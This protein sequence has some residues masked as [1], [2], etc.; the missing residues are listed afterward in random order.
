LLLLYV[1]SVAAEAVFVKVIFEL[2][3]SAPSRSATGGNQ[4]RMRLLFELKTS[5]RARVVL[6]PFQSAQPAAISSSAVSLFISAA[7]ISKTAC[8]NSI[9]V[10]AFMVVD[11]YLFYLP[12]CRQLIC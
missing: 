12:L 5:A 10:L 2:F 11:L 9:I 8:S 3:S 1:L 7:M 6:E 4:D